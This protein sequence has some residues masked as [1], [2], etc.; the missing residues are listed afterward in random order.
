MY[1]VI[2][3]LTRDNQE[4]NFGFQVNEQEVELGLDILSGFVEKGDKLVEVLL[5]FDNNV[6]KLPISIFDGHSFAKPIK[7]L[8]GQ[9]QEILRSTPEWQMKPVYSSDLLQRAQTARQSK[10]DCLKVSREQMQKLLDRASQ[11][12]NNGLLLNHYQTLINAYTRMLASYE[13]R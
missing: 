5:V 1:F 9:W 11:Q 10:I 6:T 3:A 13:A 8:Q 2:D 7:Q 4:R 12:S